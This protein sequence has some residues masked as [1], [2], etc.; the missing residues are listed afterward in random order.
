[1]SQGIRHAPLFTFLVDAAEI[2]AESHTFS[3][4]PQKREHLVLEFHS[5]VSCVNMSKISFPIIKGNRGEYRA[6][7]D[8][9]LHAMQAL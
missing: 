6:R 2:T 7:T 5:T 8:D 3:C 4:V 9:L 1:M